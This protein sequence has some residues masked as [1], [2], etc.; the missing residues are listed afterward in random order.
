LGQDQTADK[1]VKKE[2]PD[3]FYSYIITGLIFIGA[4]IPTDKISV[5]AEKSNLFSILLSQEVLHGCGF[6]LLTWILCLD[7]TRAGGQSPPYRFIGL[8]AL[9]YG[10]VIESWHL[11]LPYRT[12]ELYDIGIDIFGSLTG[13]T[14]F[15]FFR[16]QS[17]K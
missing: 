2:R 14:I 3:F 16:R 4:T 6:A 8:L 7:F 9:A 5:V 11:L 13:L 12:F 10:V 15:Y 1:N 17:K